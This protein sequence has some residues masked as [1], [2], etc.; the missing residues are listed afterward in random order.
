MIQELLIDNPVADEIHG[1]R[2]TLGK[3]KE[4]LNDLSEE[5]KSRTTEATNFDLGDRAYCFYSMTEELLVEDKALL[6]DKKGKAYARSAA[7]RLWH[8]YQH[9]GAQLTAEENQEIETMVS[10]KDKRQK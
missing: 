5:S 8:L 3:I 7:N 9:L 6:K 2:D 1:F 4:L 10:P